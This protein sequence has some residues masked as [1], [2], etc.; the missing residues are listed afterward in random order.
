MSELL[1]VDKWPFPSDDIDIW[2]NATP[3]LETPSQGGSPRTGISQAT[4]EYMDEKR[5][6]IE[7]LVWGG[8]G[9]ETG[10]TSSGTRGIAGCDGAGM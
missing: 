10:E 2:P 9:T 1:L 5:A 7:D 4:R 6:S 8:T 3:A